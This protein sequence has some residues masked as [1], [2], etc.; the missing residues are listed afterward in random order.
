[1]CLNEIYISFYNFF[2]SLI[3]VMILGIRINRVFNEYIVENTYYVT[4]TDDR[5]KCS[6]VLK[7]TLYFIWLLLAG[8]SIICVYTI[9]KVMFSLY[10]YIQF[11]TESDYI[12]LFLS[13]AFFLVFPRLM[14]LIFYW[15]D[16]PISRTLGGSNLSIAISTIIRQLLKKLRLLHT[17]IFL[18]VFVFVYLVL[19]GFAGDIFTNNE[20]RNY[21]DSLIVFNA[22]VAGIPSL[23]IK[24]FD[25]LINYITETDKILDRIFDESVILNP[26]ALSKTISNFNTTGLWPK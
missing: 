17:I 1:M 8:A 2:F 9:L 5:K 6:L 3:I 13:S 19:N 24:L 23:K 12:S 15:L 26:V 22:I 14:Y 16:K 11:I 21:V 18:N 7:V 4:D 10:E 25:E 20:V